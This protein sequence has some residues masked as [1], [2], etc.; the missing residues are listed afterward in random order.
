[1]N[2]PD[3]HK[4]DFQGEGRACAQSKKEEYCKLKSKADQKWR[5]SRQFSPQN[6]R[7]LFL[8]ILLGTNCFIFSRKLNN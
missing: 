7:I 6:V 2:S 1:M 8:V 3:R 5:K 4:R